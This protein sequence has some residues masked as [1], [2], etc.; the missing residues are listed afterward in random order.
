MGNDA[1]KSLAPKDYESLPALESPGGYIC[2]IRDID[3]DRYRIEATHAPTALVESVLA[4]RKRGFGIELVALLQTEDLAASEAELFARHHARLSSEWLE[5]DAHQLEELRQSALQIDAE[6]SEYLL[7]AIPSSA[8]GGGGRA[9]GQRFRPKRASGAARSSSRRAGGDRASRPLASQHYGHWTIDRR[10]RRS[11]SADAAAAERARQANSH[12]TADLLHLSPVVGFSIILIVAFVAVGMMRDRTLLRGKVSRPAAVAVESPTAMPA[13]QAPGPTP[14]GKPFL[15]AQPAP[16][17]ACP[18]RSCRLLQSLPV[19]TQ[20]RG[21]QAVKG[22]PVN[23]ST[24]WIEFR[25]EGTAYV[26]ISYLIEPP[27]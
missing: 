3:R 2:V 16:A 15:V 4:E 12:W 9:A 1:V 25:L 21:L 27:E 20:I 19:W 5:L 6:A 11:E 8:T 24:I 22:S 10:R 26:P 17:H 14:E 23:G 18:S 13:R 7:N